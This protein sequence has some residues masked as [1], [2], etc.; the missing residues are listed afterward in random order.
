MIK[1]II[2][3]SLLLW[4]GKMTFAQFSIDSLTSRSDSLHKQVTSDLDYY[5]DDLDDSYIPGGLL[6]EKGIPYF[7]LSSYSG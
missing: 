1:N 2:L 4:A 5:F 6:F 3:T 7:D